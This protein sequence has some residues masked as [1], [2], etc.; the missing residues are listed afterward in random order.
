[1]QATGRFEN[2]FSFISKAIIIRPEDQRWSQNYV[3]DA[4][5]Q[6]PSDP[7]IAIMAPVRKPSQR[8]AGDSKRRRHDGAE[9][10]REQTEFEYISRFFEGV[11][12]TRKSPQQVRAQQPLQ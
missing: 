12:S 10:A 9:H 11:A 2:A 5:S 8:Q 7:N 3:S 4:V 1:M 6:P